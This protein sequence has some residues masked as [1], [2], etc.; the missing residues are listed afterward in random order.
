MSPAAKP[1]A[2]SGWARCWA[3]LFACLLALA[4]GNDEPKTRNAGGDAGPTGDS[5][6]AGQC[7]GDAECTAAGK[8]CDPF[9]G[10]VECLIDAHCSTGQRCVDRACETETACE[11]SADC[12]TGSAYAACAPTTHRCEACVDD[13][14]CEGTAHC[15]GAERTGVRFG[16]ETGDPMPE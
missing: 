4:C 12:D 2:A 15:A 11:T 8:V 10:C 14:D 3:T 16:P 9:K 1:W 6:L 5:P 7:T 13:G